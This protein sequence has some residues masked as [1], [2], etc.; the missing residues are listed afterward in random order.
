MQVYNK[1]PLTIDQ[2]I[3]KL[4]NRGLEF[5]DKTSAANY[6]SNISYYRLRAYTY[7]FQDNDD[8]ENDHR[9]IR[10]GIS[11]NDII[12][13]YCFD[14]RLRALVFNALEKIEVAART[15]IIYTYSI[16]S[17]DSHWYV[18][19]AHYEEEC[20]FDILEKEM[21]D[22]IDRSN[23]DF[24]KH[25]DQKYSQPDFPPS[26]MGLEVVSFGTLS[27]LYE[28]LKAIAK[29]RLLISLVFVMSKS[30]RTGFTLYLT[31]ETVVLITAG[32]GIA[33]LWFISKCHITPSVLLWIESLCVISNKIRYLPC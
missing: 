27:K 11:F 32:Y 21:G 1:K 30:W 10:K 17:N 15:K 13:L 26:W 19:D 3:A 22:D 6:L 16:A 29:K 31:C 8:P 23:E 9:F 20:K 28:A 14:R 12:D 5:D 24:I 7:P 25:Y 2:Q 33:V 4:E 18:D